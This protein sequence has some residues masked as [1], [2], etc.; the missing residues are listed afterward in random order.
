MVGA[1]LVPGDLDRVRKGV[2]EARNGD[3][4]GGVQRMSGTA[5]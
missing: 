1:E 5:R 4:G 3:L 2:L